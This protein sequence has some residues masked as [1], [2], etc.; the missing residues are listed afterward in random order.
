MS[1]YQFR[2]GVREKVGLIISAA[3]PSGSGKTYTAMRLATGIVGPGKKFAVIDTE[4]RR[5]LHYASMFAFDHLELKPPFRPSVYADAIRDAD[6]AGYGAIVVDSGSHEWNGE[7]G[8]LDWQE[9]ELQRMAGDDYAKRERVKMASWIKPKMAHKAMVQRLLQTRAHLIFCLRAEEK[10]DI[11][12]DAQGKNQIVPR[13][14]QPICAKDFPFEMTISFLLLP[15]RPGV[16]VPIKLQEQHRVLFPDGKPITEE[17]GRK[18]AEWA[19]GGTIPRQT[20]PD[21]A[22]PRESDLKFAEGLRIDPV[23]IPPQEPPEAPQ[24]APEPQPPAAEAPVAEV[25][26]PAP[27]PYRTALDTKV[28]MRDADWS[29]GDAETEFWLPTQRDDLAFWFSEETKRCVEAGSMAKLQAMWKA[30]GAAVALIREG[31]PATYAALDKLKN[32][33]KAAIGGKK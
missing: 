4:A 31:D 18:L 25:A 17:T 33:A 15:E 6:K 10:V 5:A 16:P 27:E 19:N 2:P 28:M 32:Q 14:Y 8:V 23:A 26:A 29:P 1:T 11:V 7:G 3:G 30:N 22:P 20:A 13:G 9:A 12:K 24:D 21:P